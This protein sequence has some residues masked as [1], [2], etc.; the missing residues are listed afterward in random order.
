MLKIESENLAIE[1]SIVQEDKVALQ[2]AYK[3]LA[4]KICNQ[5]GKAL[6]QQLN[7]WQ[8]PAN[9]LSSY[10][11]LADKASLVSNYIDS[12]DVLSDGNGNISLAMNRNTLEEKGLPS[13]IHKLLEYGNESIPPL[14]HI[15]PIL[16]KINNQVNDALKDI[17]K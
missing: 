7:A 2:K 8:V 9:V 1:T 12:L 5:I 16:F 17:V 4:E 14:P 10:A 3:D 13:N 6:R 11:F 15:R